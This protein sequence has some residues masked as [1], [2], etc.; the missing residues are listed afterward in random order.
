MIVHNLTDHSI[1]NRPTRKPKILKVAG[2]VIEPGKNEE[3]PDHLLEVSDIA[4]WI[5][6]MSVSIDGLPEWYQAARRDEQDKAFKP[7]QAK[8]KKEKKVVEDKPKK[9]KPE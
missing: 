6:S 1:P 9:D 5:T 2:R 7:Q 4:G 3:I 8:P